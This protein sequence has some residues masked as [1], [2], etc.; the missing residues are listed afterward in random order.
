M[1]PVLNIQP[2]ES[3][4]GKLNGPLIIS[5]PC[6]AESE[7]QV[8]KTAHG[9]S[10]IPNIKI[11]RAGIWK[12]RTRP[13]MFEG[14]G[15][16]ALPW[17]K[18]VKEETGLLT[19][20]EVA[21]P[22]HIEAALKNNIDIL[23]IGARTVVN[24]F[25]L[26]ELAT[27]LE[28]VDIPV[29]VKNPVNPDLNLWLGAVERFM[30]AGI[31]KIAA[32]H[33]GFYFFD[34]TPYRNAPMWEI[35]IELKRRVPNL[36]M[37]CDPSHICGERALLLDIAQK[38]LDLEMDGLMIESHFDPDHALTDPQQQ[39][40]P[41]DLKI[42]IDSLVIRF[43]KG[44]NEFENRL[45][46]LRSEIDKIDAELL[47]ILSRRMSLVE[48]IGNYKV[49]HNITILQL[50]RWSNIVSDRLKTGIN[51]GLSRDF[52]VKLLENVHTESIRKQT[53]IYMKKPKG[54]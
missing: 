42:L 11:F 46:E 7:E 6:S 12:P 25:S 5:G 17:L 4:L 44:S 18:K 9:L 15:E 39:L 32:V 33:R 22:S 49:D 14:M 10:K 21:N 19:A 8:L 27:T 41:E 43:E 37:I 51:V 50:K 47:H 34:K 29:M 52:L 16:K 1:A 3:W 26:Q 35:P 20:V 30:L 23:W 45:E 40:T 24:P 54:K 36:P 38:A 48:E 31:T 28:G 53:E 13:G 2:L